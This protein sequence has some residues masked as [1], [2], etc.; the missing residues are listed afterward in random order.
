MTSIRE[1]IN[2]A[3]RKMM[4]GNRFMCDW[5][6]FDGIML[7]DDDSQRLYAAID[8]VWSACQQ[9]CSQSTV[10]IR[11]IIFAQQEHR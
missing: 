10:S 8:G 3:G 2:E 5:R 4:F 7:D 11:M 1:Q 6:E 9:A